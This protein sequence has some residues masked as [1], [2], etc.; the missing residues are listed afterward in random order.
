MQLSVLAEI[1]LDCVSVLCMQDIFRASLSSM[2][3]T[4]TTTWNYEISN[5]S[6]MYLICLRFRHPWKSCNDV[7]QYSRY[8][9]INIDSWDYMRQW[10]VHGWFEW[11][12][13]SCSATD[14][15]LSNAPRDQ[16]KVE[17]Y[18]N[19]SI[20]DS[21]KCFWRCRQQNCGNFGQASTYQHIAA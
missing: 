21:K 14:I 18:Q 19:T 15:D 4:A 11:W 12:L 13:V 2:A 7:S 5:A 8:L 16:S 10:T 17:A 3:A 6:N 9:Q 1:E 20:V